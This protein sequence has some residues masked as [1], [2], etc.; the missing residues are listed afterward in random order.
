MTG[1]LF[2]PCCADYRYFPEHKYI[3]LLVFLL[4][5]SIHMQREGM[6]ERLGIQGARS[7]IHCVFMVYP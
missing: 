4:L 3:S 7:S 1:I 6:M 2:L 5:Y